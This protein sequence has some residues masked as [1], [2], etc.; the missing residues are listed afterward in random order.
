M[1]HLLRGWHVVV[2]A[3]TVPERQDAITADFFARKSGYR[4]P[5]LLRGAGSPMAAPGSH[6]HLPGGARH[7]DLR[8][9]AVCALRAC[10]RGCG[11]EFGAVHEPEAFG[12]PVLPPGSAAPAG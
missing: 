2:R 11:S 5:T 9:F 8:Y 4:G 7:G 3:D 10:G 12:S 6:A 1:F